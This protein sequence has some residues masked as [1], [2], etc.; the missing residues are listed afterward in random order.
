MQNQVSAERVSV[1]RQ[2][3]QQLAGSK[4]SISYDELVKRFHAAHHPRVL[5]REKKTETVFNDFTTG[6]HEYVERG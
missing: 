2:A 6:I 1:V 5:T 3:W 4:D